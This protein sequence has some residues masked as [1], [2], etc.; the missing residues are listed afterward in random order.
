MICSCCNS[1]KIKDYYLGKEYFK[2]C[3]NCDYFFSYPFK[4]KEYLKEIYNEDYFKNN[5]SLNSSIKDLALRKKQY[6]QDYKVII[7]FIKKKGKVIDYGCGSGEFLQFFKKNYLLFGYDFNPH[8]RKRKNIIYLK[9]NFYQN[10]KNY[11][12]L[13]ILR[14]TIEHLI[15]PIKEI[16]KILNSLKKNGILFITA[17]PNSSNYLRLLFKDKWRQI[18]KEHIHHFNISNLSYALAKINLFLIHCELP[19]IKTPYA[20]L[21]KD[22]IEIKNRFILRQKKKI[23]PAGPGSMMTLVYIKK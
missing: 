20:N 13:V 2:K 3:D 17:T 21:N 4:S 11:F 16:K 6:L 9:K 19:Y 1:K 12:D 15:N 23:S 22:I 14:G 7:N 5:Y 10:K 18:H 8:V